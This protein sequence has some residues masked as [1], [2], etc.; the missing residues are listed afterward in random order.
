MY[1]KTMTHL[2]TR[3]SNRSYRTPFRSVPLHFAAAC[4]FGALITDIAYWVSAEMTW[5][6]FSAW[7]LTAGL[8]LSCLA[9]IALLADI[10]V[11]TLQLPR[12]IVVIYLIGNVAVFIT[13]LFNTFIHSRDA[14]TSVVPS[15]L[16]LSAATVVLMVAVAIS[17]FLLQR[18]SF[19]GTSL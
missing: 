12:G 10:F 3:L 14:W 18:R 17:G 13:A 11:G 16:A 5:A 2:D 19:Q 6:N 1:G 9:G 7:L 8:A 4:F 15:G